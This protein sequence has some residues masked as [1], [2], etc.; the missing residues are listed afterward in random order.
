MPNLRHASIEVRKC[1]A[2]I[3]IKSGKYEPVNAGTPVSALADDA[4]VA[5][6]YNRNHPDGEKITAGDVRYAG[7]YLR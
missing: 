3:G 6:V 5:I 4:V 7:V 2:A 1:A